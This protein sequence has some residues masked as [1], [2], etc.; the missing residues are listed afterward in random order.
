MATPARCR[1][2]RNLLA[3][4]NNYLES[5]SCPIIHPTTATPARCRGVHNLL[6]ILN[7][8]LESSSCPIVHPTTATPA[9]YRLDRLAV[10]LR[11]LLHHNKA[12]YDPKGHFTTHQASG[13]MTNMADWR[14]VE[15]S[16]SRKPGELT[17]SLVDQSDSYSCDKHGRLAECRNL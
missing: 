17:S 7:N 11:L 6:A 12:G 13:L 1:G 16:D 15:T 2:V 3:I 8:Y 9:R 5:S 10:V 4:L 14:N